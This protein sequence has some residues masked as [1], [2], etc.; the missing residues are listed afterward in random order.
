[1]SHALSRVESEALRM[2]DLVEDLLLLARLDAG[3]P[4]DRAPVDLSLLAV[5][6]VSDAHAAAPG[7]RWE[8]DLPE[9]PVEVS[10]DQARLHQVVANLLANA[11][12]HTPSG[13]KV[14]TSVRPDGA[15]VRISVTDDGP[16][17]PEPLQPNVFRRFT[18]G[19]DSRNRAGGSTGLGLS[20]VDAVTRSHGG[21]VELDSTPGHTR[22]S[23]LLPAA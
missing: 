11:R 5:D 14:V 18:R 15:W 20:I 23:V 17:I 3:R 19:D 16:G 6:A 7:H 9:E 1:V 21:H 8:L 2:Q 4:L 13:T 10:G 12:T 22:F